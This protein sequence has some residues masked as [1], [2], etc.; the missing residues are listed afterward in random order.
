[1]IYKEKPMPKK[2]ENELHDEAL[3]LEEAKGAE[4]YNKKTIKSADA[5]SEDEMPMSEKYKKKMKEREMEDDEDEDEDKEELEE[6]YASKSELMAK[7]VNYASKMHKHDLAQAVE[8]IVH[9]A[10][11]I[12]AKNDDATDVTDMSKK[13]KASIK[14]ATAPMMKEDIDFLF[15]SEELTE[16]FKERA[17]TLFEAAVQTRLDLLRVGV[18]EEY[19]QKLSEAAE[20]YDA[21][22][23][24][25]IEQILSET[26]EKVNDYLSYAVQEYIEE[27]RVEIEN[28]LK[29]ELTES[30][31]QGLKG[32]FDEHYV[33]VPDD[34]LDIVEGLAERVEELENEINEQTTYNIELKSQLQEMEIQNIRG[35]LAEGLTDIQREKFFTLSE[36]LDYTSP[37]HFRQKAGYILESFKAT[38]GNDGAEA[39]LNEEVDLQEETVKKISFDP[40]MSAYANAIK[41]TIKR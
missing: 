36:S 14:S 29:A 32:L 18:E 3:E 6:A 21:S 15:G 31:L 2:L 1:M 19:E 23:T 27:N 30:F 24:E 35:E 13:N 9:S 33:E 20:A 38:T 39:M 34:K 28:T 5:P 12:A 17:T 41:K 16:D 40:S 26:E 7:M 10:E 8:R 4:K 22:L 25:S 37:E 11:E